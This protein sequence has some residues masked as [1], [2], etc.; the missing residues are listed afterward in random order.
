MEGLKRIILLLWDG[1]VTFEEATKDFTVNEMVA[2]DS[3]VTSH[4]LYKNGVPFPEHI[5]EFLEE[6][7]AARLVQDMVDKF[8]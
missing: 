1:D 4:P 3:L 8:E 2:M 5:K 6:V 7:P